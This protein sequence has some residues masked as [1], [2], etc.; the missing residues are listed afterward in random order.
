MQNALALRPSLLAVCLAVGVG[1]APAQSADATER[2]RAIEFFERRIRPV[3]AQDCYECHSSQ[4]KPKGGLALDHREA[5]L[6]GG[7]S[8]P[9]IVPGDPAASRLLTAIRRTDPQLQMPKARAP[10][11]ATVVDDFVTWI[12]DGAIDPRDGPPTAEQLAQDTDWNAVVQRRL[13]WWSFQPLRPPDAARSDAAGEE[14]PIDRLLRGG[15]AAMQLAPEPPADRA[16]LLRRLSFALRGLPPSVAEVDAFV[17]SESPRAFAQQVDAWLAS[18]QFGER[19]A[20]HWMDWL[21]YA[22]SHGSEGDPLIPYA[23]RYRDYL[24]RALQAD[25]PYDQLVREHLAGDLLPTPR[26]DATTGCNE[27]AFGTAHLR[28]VFHGYAPTDPL[29]EKGRFTDDQIDVVSKAFLGLTVACARCH[30]HKFDPI[31]QRD[32]TALYGVFATG[33]PAV[34]DAAAPDAE[35][36]RERERLAADLRS[37]RRDLAESYLAVAATLAARLTGD[38]VLVQP[39]IQRATQPTDLLHAFFVLQS[40]NPAAM[41]TAWRQ[42]LAATPGAA[43]WQWNLAATTDLA[44]WRRVGPGVHQAARAGALALA[45]T[46]DAVL[47]G[48]YPAGTYSHLASTIDRAVLL[49]PRVQLDQPYDL[50]LRVV[51][52]GGAAVRPVVQDYPRDGSV[53]PITALDGGAWRWVRFSLDY[54][55]GDELHV[56]LATAADQPVLART[57]TLRS[58]FG[59][60]EVRLVPR[61]TPAPQDDCA[62]A[63][64]ILAALGEREPTTAAQ[65]A[66]AYAQALHAAATAWRD[67]VATDAQALLLDAL[68]HT[69]LLPNRVEQ[70]PAP[71]AQRVMDCRQAIARLR[72]PERVPGVIE[73][74]PRDAALLL[75]G[76]HKQP[77][78]LVPRRSLALLGGAPC[79]AD[80]SGRL[81]LAADWTRRDNP[82]VARVLVNRVWRQLFGR[83]LVA[84]PDNFGHLGATP[85]HPELLD[86][87]AA[88]FMQNGWSIQR[89]I[90]Q[91]VSSAAWQRASTP[92]AA[93]RQ[94]DPDNLWLSHFAV[95]RLDAEAIRDALLAIAGDLQP[96]RFGPSVGGDVPRRSVYVRSKRNEPDPLLA[97]FDAPVPASC[98]G[99]RDATNVPAQALTLLNDPFVWTLAEH[100]AQR[101]EADAT[102]R[103]PA[104]RVNAMHLAAFARKPTAMEQDRALAF[105]AAAEATIA[106]AARERARV[107]EAIHSAQGE[108][109]Q[110]TATLIERVERVRRARPAAA[111]TSTGLPVPVLQWNFAAVSPNPADTLAGTG[112]IEQGALVLD[113]IGAHLRSVPLAID[114]RA[115]TLA[116]VVQLDGLAQQGGGVISLQDGKGDVFDA[117][118][119]GEQQPG[120]W[121]AGSNGF[122]RT[123]RFGGSAEASA[124]EE[125]VHL[126]ITYAADGTVTGYR[127]GELY[128]KPYQTTPPVTFQRGDAQVLLGLRHGEPSGN[129]LLRGS[130][131]AAWLFDRALTAEQVRSQATSYRINSPDQLR[132]A[133]SP[134]EAARL[135]ELTAELTNARE[136]LQALAASPGATSPWASL[137]LALFNQKE[138]VYLR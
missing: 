110:L 34:I 94:H 14:H 57:G 28:M 18:P 63:A 115:K 125:P 6:R 111:R 132:E 54:W 7:E 4:G 16:V 37:V 27:S 52:D 98:Q 55:T 60:R 61:G 56:E 42:R 114:V 130:I 2:G 129:R 17:R 116:A 66:A 113:G 50:W 40:G 81:E 84:S 21:R 48:V 122:A 41:F 100:W 83:G 82:L 101:L 76:D 128:G 20:R 77:G 119:F 99:Q 43:S 109:Q 51:G 136:Q 69:G 5:L 22:D 29:A 86:W 103:Q 127:N 67:D 71:I 92:S 102:L 49:S 118:V 117:I 64:P 70:L 26:L 11:T 93:A 124:G 138:F 58:W 13:A 126:A 121:L 25:V 33:A 87:L 137:A 45:H 79:A 133:A 23:F 1:I 62:F 107:Q 85:S 80:S 15:L 89:L 97:A 12:R 120:H 39:S 135:A 24:I 112:Q 72:G 35:Q 90:R 105:V 19:W 73:H 47:L 88:D 74:A 59:V 123:Q 44:A 108:L 104:V 30:D 95:R 68:L 3:L 131:H 75:R 65:L 46:G 78:V 10:L 31:S 32:Y 96:E 91:I 9:A 36:D 38:E 8:G 53:F 106:T 134:A